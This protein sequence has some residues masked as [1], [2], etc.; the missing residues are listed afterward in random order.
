MELT[1]KEKKEFT[2]IP[3]IPGVGEVVERP[4]GKSYRR[5]VGS[6]CARGDPPTCSHP[7]VVVVGSSRRSLRPLPR[8]GRH[9]DLARRD[10]HEPAPGSGPRSSA[11]RPLSVRRRHGLPPGP[12]IRTSSSRSSGWPRVPAG[13]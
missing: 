10:P 6:G 11:S 8:P 4:F 12:W 3:G 5:R 13:P 1:D 2:L 7:A 9:A